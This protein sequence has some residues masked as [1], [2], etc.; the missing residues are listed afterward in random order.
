M[1]DGVGNQQVDDRAGRPDPGIAPGDAW[2]PRNRHERKYLKALWRRVK[3]LEDREQEYRRQR[4][5]QQAG[6]W[7]VMEAKALRWVL[8]DVLGLR[9]DEGGAR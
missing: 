9:D 4:Q 7:D 2:S 1:G 3:F 5:A 6:S 8:V